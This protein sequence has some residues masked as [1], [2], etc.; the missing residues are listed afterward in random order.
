MNA[1]KKSDFLLFIDGVI[2][3]D[4]EML[5][6]MVGVMNLKDNVGIV[7]PIIYE[8]EDRDN[9]WSAGVKIN[10][11][12]GR[13]ILRKGRNTGRYDNVE[14]VQAAS[15][16]MLVKRELIEK[17]GGF[18]EKYYATYEDLDFCL[19]AKRFGYV[20]CYTPHAIAYLDMNNYI[21]EG[22]S[23]FFKWSYLVARNRIYLLGKH[24]TDFGMFLL[25]TPFHLVSFLLGD[26]SNRVDTLKDYIMGVKDGLI[27]ELLIKRMLIHIFYSR[28]F[29]LKMSL[30][31]KK[32]SIL[33]VGCG[34]GELMEMLNRD[35]V[36]KVDGIDA[37]AI[38]AGLAR[39]TG[40]YSK[41]LVGDIRDVKKY[42]KGKKYDIVFCSQV[43]EHL[44]KK[45]ALKLIGDLE[46]IGN[47]IVLATPLGFL[48]KDEPYMGE[49]DNPYQAHRSAWSVGDYESRGYK[50]YGS[51]VKFLFG[52]DG[53]LAKS[54]NVHKIFSLLGQFIA[55][56]LASFV[57]YNPKYSTGA[58]AIK[59]IKVA[60]SF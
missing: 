37:Y 51:G 58:L 32:A 12:T 52:D 55:L 9:V 47:K 56:L 43:L 20:T 57:F 50:V 15:G 3:T 24:G 38:D 44:E 4:K 21:K 8:R 26:G 28:I 11:L 34:N 59:R 48:E 19:N 39:T 22:K 53:I 40:V 33:D 1:G 46:K 23:M 2:S 41:V 13:I 18:D 6:E 49:G 35:R 14:K 16:V 54:R 17:I 60:Q 31:G 7:T 29:V 10:L 5:E 27:K 45:D 36:W 25:C 42:V 30:G